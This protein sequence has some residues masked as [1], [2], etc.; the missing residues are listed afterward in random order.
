MAITNIKGR[1]VALYLEKSPGTY[2]RMKCASSV[3]LNITTE[4]TEVSCVESGNF[5][6]FEPGDTSWDGSL[7][8]GVRQATST[9]AADNITAENLIDMQLA[10]T[11]FLVRF[12]LGTGTGA[13][14]YGGKVFITSNGTTGDRAS[15]AALS[16]SFRGTGPLTKSLEPA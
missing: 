8:G 10:G 15:A 1:D 6:E 11:T 16:T 14:R 13:A 5:K 2:V 12:T 9:D 4:E 7:D 3:N